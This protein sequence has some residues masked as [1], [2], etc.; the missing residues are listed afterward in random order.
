MDNQPDGFIHYFPF[1]RMDGCPFEFKEIFFVLKSNFLEISNN[2][3]TDHFMLFILNSISRLPHALQN[4]HH[5][6]QSLLSL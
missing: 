4:A 5:A 6:A 3:L 2:D 1:F